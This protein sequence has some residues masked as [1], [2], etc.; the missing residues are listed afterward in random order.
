MSTNDTTVIVQS[1]AHFFNMPNSHLSD[2]IFAPH[3]VAHVPMLLPLSQVGFKGF[4]QGLH[5]AFPDLHMSIDESIM[6]PN[7]VVLRTTFYGTHQA[8]F[9]GILASGCEIVT[10][11]ISLFHTCDELITESWT[12][13][14]I[15]G[16]IQQISSYPSSSAEV[17]LRGCFPN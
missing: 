2:G 15:L 14:D 6:L 10:P 11:S 7:T 4:V 17:L 5:L 8:S 9:L 16:V 12:E 3:F 13:M 1:L